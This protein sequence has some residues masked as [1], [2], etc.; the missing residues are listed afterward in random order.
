[1]CHKSLVKIYWDLIYIH[2]LYGSLE[3][4]LVCKIKTTTKRT[5]IQYQRK[6]LLSMLYVSFGFCH[7][8]NVRILYPP[9]TLLLEWKVDTDCNYKRLIE[10]KIKVI[11]LFIDRCVF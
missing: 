11:F 10:I 3:H 9:F 2:L 1:M 4:S 6:S 5:K 8:S 7:F